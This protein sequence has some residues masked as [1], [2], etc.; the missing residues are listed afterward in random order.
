[1]KRNKKIIDRD[2][3]ISID[4][5]CTIQF[6]KEQLLT[7]LCSNNEPDQTIGNIHFSETSVK[8]EIISSLSEMTA[9]K[10]DTKFVGHLITVVQSLSC[11]NKNHAIYRFD[12][13]ESWFF[14]QQWL[15]F[16]PTA[17]I[18]KQLNKIFKNSKYWSK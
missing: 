16:Q 14:Q 12:G 5:K 8:A 2:Q 7:M 1:M 6:A 15:I 4:I 13:I 11:L 9:T 18:R 17:T 3:P 10:T